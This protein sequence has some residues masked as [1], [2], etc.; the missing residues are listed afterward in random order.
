MS[1]RKVSDSDNPY[2][3]YN[4]ESVI[5]SYSPMFDKGRQNENVRYGKSR[6]RKLSCFGF[7]LLGIFKN[8]GCVFI[9]IIIIA[10]V[11][12]LHIISKDSAD[13]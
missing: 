13:Q 12:M 6:E 11:S 2:P 10:F 7:C 5:Q 3:S 9:L 1:S 4:R 8:L